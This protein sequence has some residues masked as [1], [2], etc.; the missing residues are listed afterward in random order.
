MANVSKKTTTA[1]SAETTTTTPLTLHTDA[2]DSSDTVMAHLD[3]LVKSRTLSTDDEIF[4][5]TG[6][7]GTVAKISAELNAIGQEIPAAM[8]VLWDEEAKR[9]DSVETARQETFQKILDRI[10]KEQKKLQSGKGGAGTLGSMGSKL[11]YGSIGS[12]VGL[13]FGMMLSSLIVM[14]RQ[15]S[16]ARGADG[17]LIEWLGTSE[18]T[19][20]RRSFASGNKS[21]TECVEKAKSMKVAVKG[22]KITCLLE[23]K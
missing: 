19:L 5:I 16:V 7:A 4:A 17:A 15:V 8:Q 10:L 14:P 23:I 3:A 20:M 22:Q 6:M 2:L 21:V 13:A 18:G 9:R 1:K 12:T 11:L